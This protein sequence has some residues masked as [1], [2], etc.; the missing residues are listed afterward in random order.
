MLNDLE[1]LDGY[2]VNNTTN[3]C[4]SNIELM[5][6]VKELEFGKEIIKIGINDSKN[7]VYVCDDI[8]IKRE[9]DKLFYI[10]FLDKNHHKKQ[11]GFN[12]YVYCDNA[13]DAVIDLLNAQYNTGLASMDSYDVKKLMNNRYYKYYRFIINEPINETN[14][15]IIFDNIDFKNKNYFFVCYSGINM[16][17]MELDII[18]D[19]LKNRSD[20]GIWLC[21]FIDDKLGDYRI[22]SL[23]IE[24]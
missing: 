24:E 5:N 13:S 2:Y 9:N 10:Q 11:E 12:S 4:T 20:I 7:I 17:L 16:S 23:F 15:N 21:W 1:I 14:V 8:N 18:A 3:I 6:R 19:E 22:V